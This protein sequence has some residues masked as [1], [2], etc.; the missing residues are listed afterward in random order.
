[1]IL[2]PYSSPL[3]SSKWINEFL[4]ER[5]MELRCERSVMGAMDRR[6][7]SGSDER[8]RMSYSTG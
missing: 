6:R 1:M 3:I 4:G 2:V 5:G 7:E 8:E